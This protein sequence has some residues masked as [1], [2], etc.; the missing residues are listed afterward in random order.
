MSPRFGFGPSDGADGEE[1]QNPN[2]SENS[3]QPQFPGMDELM[4][5]FQSFGFNPG[6]LFSQ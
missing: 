5:Q 3:G 4:S 6:A 2:N 1:E